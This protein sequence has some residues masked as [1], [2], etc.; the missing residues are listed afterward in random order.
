MEG[1]SLC[2]VILAV[3]G[4]IGVFFAS[5]L[6]KHYRLLNFF[7]KNGVPYRKPLPLI[8]N[9]W[10]LISK[11][12]PFAK[13][14]QDLYKE[15]PD[16]KYSGIYEFTHP[17][18]L[19]RDPELIKNVMVKYFDHF[20]NHRDF[21]DE[22]VDP[23][24]G[25]N[26]FAMKDEKWKEMRSIVTPLFT[27]SKMRAM[28]E[29]I[30]KCGDDFTE[31]LVKQPLPLTLELKEVYTRFTNDVIATSA[32]GVSVNSL[33]NEKNEFYQM[34]KAATEPNISGMVKL[35]I[36]NWNPAA[37]KFF[38][39]KLFPT[40]VSEFFLGLVTDTIKTREREAI[41]RPDLIHLL[42]HAKH[43]NNGEK[44]TMEEVTSQSILFFF[45]A[46]DTASSLMC[47]ASHQLAI[48]PDIQEK[49]IAEVDSAVEK[50]GEK[51]SYET[52]NALPYFEMFLN[53]TLRYYSPVMTTDRISNQDFE[54]PPVKEGAKPILTKAGT[55]VWLPIYAL[56]HDPEYFPDPEKFNPER[57][58]PE[59]KGKI[60][61]YAYVPFGVGPRSCPG[62]RFALLE[63]KLV[64]SNILRKF[65]IR[66]G[67][68][69]VLPVEFV[70]LTPTMGAKDGFWVD[71]V[72]RKSK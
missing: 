11:Q 5:V 57:F 1:G 29:L 9:W 38:K 63:T 13:F 50:E 31:Y 28:F 43:K 22:T 14:T 49:L 68:K 64:L 47:W 52:I 8:G 20:V 40:R 66:V 71:F 4:I 65:R 53:E 33:A 17:T 69:T 59:N 3:L 34:G 2:S 37:L 67:A 61:P 19:L 16:A 35:F 25:G 41:V 55:R 12:V 42:M 72:P 36:N 10:P 18:Y 30:R 24:F 54:L 6:W 62:N 23:L 56:H 48:H 46:F 15:F 58:S 7:K 27:S 70:P 39:L 45:A 51:L 44:L 60:N 26:L 32:F 21:V